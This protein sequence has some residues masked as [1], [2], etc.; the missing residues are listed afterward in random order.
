ML[1]DNGANASIADK[2]WLGDR[3]MLQKR[4]KPVDV[5]CTGEGVDHSN[6]DAIVQLL[7]SRSSWVQSLASAF[8]KLRK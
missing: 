3:A 1:L 4:N 5:V 2:V 8:G 7:S 6:R